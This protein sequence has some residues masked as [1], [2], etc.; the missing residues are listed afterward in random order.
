[1]TSAKQFQT[2]SVSRS[3]TEGKKPWRVPPCLEVPFHSKS[4]GGRINRWLIPPKRK[5]SESRFLEVHAT[6]KI[7]LPFNP[8]K[9]RYCKPL[10]LPQ[11]QLYGRVR[12]ASSMCSSYFP[13]IDHTLLSTISSRRTILN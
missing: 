8:G 5:V 13:G 1:M 6:M 11:K 4:Y 9:T 10:S 3:G 2:S 12:A 7:A